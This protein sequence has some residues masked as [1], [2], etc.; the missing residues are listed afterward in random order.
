LGAS[1]APFRPSRLYRQRQGVVTSEAAVFWGIVAANF[2]G[3]LVAKQAVEGGD[4]QAAA[5]PAATT[6]A[7]TTPNPT[8]S[9]RDAVLDHCRASLSALRAGRWHT[10]LTSPLVHLSAVHC[11]LN[12]FPLALCRR[13][14]PLS[15][16]ELLS[17][18]A[19]GCAAAAASHVAWMRHEVASAAKEAA[20][21]EAGGGG[22]SP[23][24][25]V[26]RYENNTPAFVG[27]SGGTAAVLACQAALAPSALAALGGVLPVP[28]VAAAFVFACVEVKEALY[29]DGPPA[30]VGAVLAGALAAVAVKRRRAAAAEAARRAVVGWAGRM[31]TGV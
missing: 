21:A 23:A 18:Y 20:A 3:V 9:A 5:A 2:V 11:A 14:V 31:T 8:L 4:G 29:S 28:V 1:A 12:L 17:T 15:G 7:T 22:A 19:L 10:L 25:L 13:A 16:A 26:A 6:A 30:K 24:D 27:S